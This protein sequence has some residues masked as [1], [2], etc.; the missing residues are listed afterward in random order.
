MAKARKGKK[1]WMSQGSRKKS[2]NR[3]LPPSTQKM[4]SSDTVVVWFVPVLTRGKLHI[5][6][7]SDNFPGE[8]PVG[9]AEMVAKVRAALNIRFQG[10]TPPKILFTDRGN[11][12]YNSTTGVITNLYRNALDAHGLKCF[13]GDNAS[14][15]P[16]QLQDF[17]LHET[18]MAWMRERLKKTVPKEA[19]NETVEDYRARLKQCAAYCN[20]KYNIENLCREVPWRAQELINLEGDRLPK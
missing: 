17:L 13:F 11:G 14:V 10:T 12:F 4:H 2:I 7:L 15:Q 19:W 8:T 20:E 9:A 6:S 3:R 1:G 5:E 18:A 16:G